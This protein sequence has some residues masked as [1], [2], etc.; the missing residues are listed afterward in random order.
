MFSKLAFPGHPHHLPAM[1]EPRVV[2]NLEENI[3]KTVG[4]RRPPRDPMEVADQL[5]KSAYQLFTRCGHK[6]TP[7]GV[8]RFRTHEE[9]NEW[10]QKTI[11]LNKTA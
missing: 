8:F 5:Q 9:A 7:R 3:G 4:R 11:R 10:Q 2:I 6:L 1:N